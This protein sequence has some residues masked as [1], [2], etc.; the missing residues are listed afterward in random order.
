MVSTTKNTFT[1][2]HAYDNGDYGI[3]LHES[4]SNTVSQA[5]TNNNIVGVEMN[6]TSMYNKLYDITSFS[7]IQK[8][9]H[10][11]KAD[12]NNMQYLWLYDNIV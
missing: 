2:V 1:N 9:L 11:F 10:L 12:Y 6:A 5:V 3:V 7:N 4:S 8:G